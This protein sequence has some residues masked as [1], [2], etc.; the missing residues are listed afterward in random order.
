MINKI[1]EQIYNFIF[2]VNESVRTGITEDSKEKTEE[3]D[4]IILQSYDVIADFWDENLYDFND[5]CVTKISDLSSKEP[6]C[7]YFNFPRMTSNTK[8]QFLNYKLNQIQNSIVK[9]GEFN[10]NDIKKSFINID[11]IGIKTILDLCEE[12]GIIKYKGKVYSAYDN[13]AASIINYNNIKSGIHMSKINQSKAEIFKTGFLIEYKD[14]GKIQDS[15]N[16]EIHEIEDSEGKKYIAKVLTKNVSKNKLKRFRNEI[17][18]GKIYKNENVIEIIDNGIKSIDGED[19]M[20]YIMPKYKSN[21]RKV[22]DE[23]IQKDKV[24]IYFNQILQGVKFIHSKGAFHR[25]LKPENI[26]YD[27]EKDKMVIADLGIAHFNEEDLIDDPKTKLTDKMANF[28]YASPEQRKK[29]NKV[30]C[31]CDI[32]SLG[33]ILNEIFT[34]EIIQGSNYKKIAEVSE[35]FSFLD[36]IVEKMTQQNP[37]NRYQ[38]IEEIQYAINAKLESYK[39]GKEIENLRKIQIEESEE[40]DILILEPI[41]IINV[42]INDMGMLGIHLNNEPNLLWKELL[43]KVDKTQIL[44]CGPEKFKFHGKSAI[45]FFSEHQM[46]SLPKIVEYFKEWVNSVNKIYPKE[47]EKKRKQEKEQ[48]ER[49][50]KA[51]IESEEKLEAIRKR[52]KI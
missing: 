16:A 34:N 19:C 8:I 9:N 13:N 49:E 12:E 25:D 48:K 35:D 52:I 6:K 47:V 43:M 7:Y 40:K 10:E 1:N 21:F 38:S 11:N 23:G 45:L 29:G 41:K 26:L 5:K 20:F 46:D 37:D 2:S 18:F 50:L 3:L 24:L 30:D 44:G 42:E 36:S 27:E 31:R 39:K 14:C 32:Y 17:N 22:I 51:K 15:S 33:L 28:Q 4:N